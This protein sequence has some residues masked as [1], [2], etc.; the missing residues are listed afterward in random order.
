MYR[1]VAF[2]DVCGLL[3]NHAV[4]I[5]SVLGTCGCLNPVKE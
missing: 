3:N 4:A 2:L 1:K 5:G